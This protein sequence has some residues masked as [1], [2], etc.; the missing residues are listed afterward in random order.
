[1]DELCLHFVEEHSQRFNSFLVSKETSLIYVK[2]QPQHPYYTR[3]VKGATPET[4]M[5]GILN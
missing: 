3:H 1:M 4:N 2:L 5:L